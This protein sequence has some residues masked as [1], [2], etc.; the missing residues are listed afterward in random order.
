M[1]AFGIAG[2]P[3]IVPISPIKK[4]NEIK[5]TW[6]LRAHKL[7][8]VTPRVPGP[9]FFPFIHQGAHGTS[10]PRRPRVRLRAG[11]AL[12]SRARKNSKARYYKCGQA[13]RLKTKRVFLSDAPPNKYI[14]PEFCFLSSRSRG[15]PNKDS[16]SLRAGRQLLEV[17]TAL[18]QCGRRAGHAGAPE[19]GEKPPRTRNS[20]LSPI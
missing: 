4:L 5:S 13:P 15:N 3:P 17:F 7:Q 9:D 14:S 19:A 8:T 18:P 12:S 6:T 10:R 16:I 1:N 2:N 11:L 20:D